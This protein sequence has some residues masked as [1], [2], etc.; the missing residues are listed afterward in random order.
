MSDVSQEVSHTQLLAHTRTDII[1]GVLIWGSA[2][3]IRSV[4]N[5]KVI[6]V[7]Q[8]TGYVT[9]TTHLKHICCSNIQVEIHKKNHAIYL[10][11]TL[12]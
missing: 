9:F 2:E 3:R 10:K 12:Q 1:L 8:F 5:V 6:T 4:H 11:L 7:K